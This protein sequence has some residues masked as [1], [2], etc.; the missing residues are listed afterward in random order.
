MYNGL[1]VSS[2]SVIDKMY[3]DFGWDYTLQFNDVLEW[4]GEALRELK[5]PCFYVDKVTDGNK[6]L[7]HKDFIHIEDGRGKLPCDLFSITQTASAVEVHPSTAKA[8]VSG[9]VYVDYNTDQTCTV[10]DGTSLC[11]SLGILTFPLLN[12]YYSL[13]FTSWRHRVYSIILSIIRI[14]FWS[15]KFYVKVSR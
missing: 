13:S 7:G 6:E 14:I 5:V 8:I 12:I 10:G 3:R 9:I 15:A 4:I 11:N 1:M 2:S